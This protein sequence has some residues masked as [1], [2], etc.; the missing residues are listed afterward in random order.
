MVLKNQNDNSS[1]RIIKTCKQKS[2]QFQQYVSLTIKPKNPA[3]PM[4]EITKI[5]YKKRKKGKKKKMLKNVNKA[6][7]IESKKKKKKKIKL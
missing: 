3:L 4:F 6:I 5:P 2:Y 1:K 7:N